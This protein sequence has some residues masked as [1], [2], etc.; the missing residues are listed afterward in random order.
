VTLRRPH[1][2]RRT[3]ARLRLVPIE[4]T[5]QC[6]GAELALDDRSTCATQLAGEPQREREVDEARLARE[7]VAGLCSVTRDHDRCAAVSRNGAT[8]HRRYRSRKDLRLDKEWHT[9]QA[10]L[11]RSDEER[12]LQLLRRRL[13]R[14]RYEHTGTRRGRLQHSCTREPS[15]TGDRQL[16]ADPTTLVGAGREQRTDDALLRQ[17]DRAMT[18]QQLLGER[19]CSTG[20][21]HHEC[22]TQ[23]C[24]ISALQ[25]REAR[26]ATH[27]RDLATIVHDGT[28]LERTLE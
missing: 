20:G 19:A 23:R 17:L 1:E 2:D 25:R 24:T 11:A 27:A 21:N 15:E 16:D 6:G 13:T 5:E 4:R 22:R 18:A 9:E 7:Y 3:D 8:R 26:M 28:M 10:M 12:V 14:C